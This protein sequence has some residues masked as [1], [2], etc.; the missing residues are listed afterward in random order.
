MSRS[1][2]SSL[3]QAEG[4]IKKPKPKARHVAHVV[5][6]IPGR[7]HVRVRKELRDPKAMA[8]LEAQLKK[9]P[10]VKSVTVNKRTGS[11]VI[12]HDKGRDGRLVL[13]EALQGAELLGGLL[14]DIP[15]GEGEDGGEYGKLDQTLADI[16]YRTDRWVYLKTGLRFRGQLL[17][18]SVAGLGILQLAVFGVSLEMLPGPL[19]LYLG[20]DI[21]HRAGK[22]PPL[23]SVKYEP[24]GG[25]AEL[26]VANPQAGSPALATA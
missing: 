21:Y 17:A 18:G 11:V 4:E 20:W 6:V 16:V 2:D 8:E 23:E 24:K 7:T 3:P 19:L 10:A 5:N 9:D 12:T 22:E 26:A 13:N 1:A 25:Q 15:A 14:L